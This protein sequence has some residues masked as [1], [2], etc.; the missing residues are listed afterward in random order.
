MMYVAPMRSAQNKE[1]EIPI[2]WAM[3]V[4]LMPWRFLR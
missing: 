4:V 3:L 2:I 1:I